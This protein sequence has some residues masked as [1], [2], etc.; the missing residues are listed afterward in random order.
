MADPRP[1][2]ARST[3]VLRVADYPRARAFYVDQLGF[4]V[5]EEGGDPPRF[6]ILRRDRAYLFLDAWQGGPSEQNPAVWS[7]YFHVTEIERVAAE[8]EARGI[9][10]AKPVH[11]TAYGMVEL[12]LRDPDGN[13]LCFGADKGP[14]FDLVRNHY[15]LA[16]HDLDASAA[17]YH[18]VLGCER[19]DVDPGNW[20]FMRGPGVT[21]MLGRCPDAIPAA[22][23][24]DHSYFAY[25]V[26]DDLAAYEARA[27]AAGAEFIKP[28]RDESWGMRELGLRTVDGHR[29]MLGQD[30]VAAPE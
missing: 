8:L 14:R 28:M 9:T 1:R 16:V 25:L 6:G 30:L 19:G 26:V 2:F 23:L 24:G 22:E 11:E 7:A 5:V 17:W 29:I 27:R 18:E 12:E 13:T 20:V 4:E 10:L 21:F 3:P 15:V